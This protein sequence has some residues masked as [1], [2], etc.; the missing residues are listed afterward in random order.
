MLERLAGPAEADRVGAALGYPGWRRGGE[1][2]IP[3][4]RWAASDLPFGLNAAFPWFHPTVGLAV[5]DGVGEIDLAAAAELYGGGSFAAR[6]LAIGIRP[7]VLTRHGLRLA[8]TPVDGAIPR[9]D[10]LIAPG[11][12]RAAALDPSVTSWAVAHG[13]HVETPGGSIEG[14]FG[15]DPILRDLARSTDRATAHATATYLEYPTGHLQLTGPAWPWRPTALAGTALAGT[16]LLITVLLRL[17]AGRV[18]RP[19][20]GRHDIRHR[21]AVSS[22]PQ[23]VRPDTAA[24][25]P[26]PGA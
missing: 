6:T 16:A 18:R 15:F 1:H 13:L 9:P 23:P 19:D 2:T 7:T 14:E 24:N 12:T 22:S 8:V 26:H 11:A 25:Q 17:T 10:R 5:S 4:H 20:A 3:V 21:Q